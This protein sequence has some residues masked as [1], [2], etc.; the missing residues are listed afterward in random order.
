M[1]ASSALAG[2]HSETR[3]FSVSGRPPNGLAC[4]GAGAPYTRMTASTDI[5]RSARLAVGYAYHR[6][7]VHPGIIARIGE[8]VQLTKRLGRALDIGCGAGLSTAAL[9]SIVDFAVGIEP[10]ESMLAHRAAVSTQAHF[11]VAKAE[12]L[13]FAAQTF[14]LM[15]AAGSLNYADLNL[16]F[17]EAARVLKPSGVLAIYDFSEGRRLRDDHRLEDWFAAF[18]QR[19][20]SPPGYGLAVKELNYGRYD[21]QLYAYEELEVAVPMTLSSY[22][23]YA[24][25]ETSVELAIA[26]GTPEDEIRAW[27]HST[28][29]DILDETPHDV[30]FDAYIAYVKREADAQA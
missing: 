4:E 22:L 6:P 21:L 14:D 19:Y 26:Q 12:Q 16:F 5:Y 23:S 18:K 9:E 17:P 24:L 7:S 13:P 15:T 30:L 1:G 25:S 28:L 10:V 29:S 27:C 20:A 8:Q 2:I 11:V 3:S